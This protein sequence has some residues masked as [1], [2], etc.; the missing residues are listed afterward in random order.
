MANLLLAARIATARPDDLRGAADPAFGQ[1][2]MPL[3]DVRSRLDPMSTELIHE[4]PSEI[5]IE[6][7]VEGAE[8]EV[9][10]VDHTVT[11]RSGSGDRRELEL[12][13][14]ADVERLTATLRD[15][16]LELHAPKREPRPRRIP[17]HD[18]TRI[19]G[20]ATAD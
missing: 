6:L 19:G 4:S 14:S 5:L 12:P 9:T 15:R 16:L 13:R 10:V 1:L 20:T 18:P 17:V 2:P 7:P 3:E 8:L 11:V